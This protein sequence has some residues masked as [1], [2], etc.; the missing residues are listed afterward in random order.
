MVEFSSAIV[1]CPKSISSWDGV[2]ASLMVETVAL[3]EPISATVGVGASLRVELVAL[4][5]RLSGTI[6]SAL[7]EERDSEML[8]LEVVVI[9]L[10]K[11]VA[12]SLA[13]HTRR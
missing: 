8:F 7:V 12:G 4:L 9:E 1:E 11:M 13:A 2:G 5:G 3:L 6:R 10:G